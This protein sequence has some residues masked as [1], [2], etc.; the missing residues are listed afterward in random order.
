MNYKELPTVECEDCGESFTVLPN[1]VKTAKRCEKCRPAAHRA[2]QTRA[3]RNWR[4]RQRELK[5][6]NIETNNQ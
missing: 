3:Q 6:K 4:Q 2:S 1:H 5:A